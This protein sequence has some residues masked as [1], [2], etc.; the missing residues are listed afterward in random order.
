MD[1]LGFSLG[2]APRLVGWKVPNQSSQNGKVLTTRQTLDDNLESSPEHSGDLK[3]MIYKTG[4]GNPGT[5]HKKDQRISLG[6]GD[7]SMFTF[8][9]LSL[10]RVDSVCILGPFQLS[11]MGDLYPM[12][13]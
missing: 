1:V 3:R 10:G 13:K 8:S 6:I 7:D 12:R 5:M 2:V 9:F 4:A 11:G